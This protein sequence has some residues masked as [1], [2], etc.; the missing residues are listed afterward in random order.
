MNVYDNKGRLPVQCC[1]QRKRRN[2]E[3][4]ARFL[5]DMDFRSQELRSVHGG[6]LELE[7]RRPPL[8]KTPLIDASESGDLA[9]VKNLIR[10]GANLSAQAKFGKTGLHHAAGNGH[11]DVVKALVGAGA[12]LEILDAEGRT[13]LVCSAQIKR[14]QWQEISR[15]LEDQTFRQEELSRS[16]AIEEDA[17]SELKDNTSGFLWID[18]ICINQADLE[19]R[20]AQVRIMPQIYSKADCVNVWLGDDSQMRFQLQKHMWEEPDLE[21]VIHR[22]NKKAEKLKELEERCE[23]RFTGAGAIGHTCS[24]SLTIRVRRVEVTA[25]FPQ[26]SRMGLGDAQARNSLHQRHQTCSGLL[27]AIMVHQGLV[28]PRTQL[29]QENPNV[30]WQNGA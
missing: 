2:W 6:D 21:D 12:D 22:V 25:V 11:Y 24:N 3:A 20:S 30:P 5:R 16:A 7:S 15:F 14:G 23:S 1:V 8:N 10:R 26:E 19:E 4:T 13:P 18:A 28:Y 27:P 29:G 17:E 9:R